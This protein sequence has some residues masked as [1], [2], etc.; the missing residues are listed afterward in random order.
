MSSPLIRRSL[1]RSALR[2][3]HYV[4]FPFLLT[5]RSRAE[6]DILP[7]GSAEFRRYVAVVGFRVRNSSP[8]NSIAQLFWPIGCALRRYFGKISVTPNVHT[9]L[10]AMMN[11]AIHRHLEW[12][13]LGLDLA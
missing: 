6:A 10:N 2:G 12:R 13:Q 3:I 7:L 11:D 9:P 5:W 4:P 8:V 1:E